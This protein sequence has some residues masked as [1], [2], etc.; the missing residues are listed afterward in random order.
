M[1]SEATVD[2]IINNA[3]SLA[4]SQTNAANTAA[5]SAI[6][7]SQG[8]AATGLP[9]VVYNIQA[10]EPP[11]A[12][13]ED[14]TLTYESQRDEIIQLLTDQMAEFFVLYYPLT[15]DAFDPAVN[16]LVN[17]ITVGG[18]GINPAVE[19]QIW[20]RDRDRVVVDG[21]RVEAQVMVD[22]ASRG[23]RFPPGVAAARLQQA[24]FEQ[25]MK[26]Q[27]QSRAVAIKQA[28]IE[29]ENLRFAVNLAIESRLRAL[30][31]AAEYLRA[32]MSG[33]DNAARVAS[34]NADVRARM[35]AA[36]A[37]LYRARLSRDEIA[38]RVPLANATNGLQA[39]GINVDGFYKG[40][41]ARV[42]A[43]AAAAD[44]YGSSAAAALSSLNS[45]ASV[46]SASFT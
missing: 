44:S 46:S 8:F 7:A 1:A 6:A 34:L 23:F 19:A 4:N 15:T 36:T 27:E 42:R 3:I 28:D 40:V 17:T 32:L 12:E 11:V 25:L 45:V 35:I 18:T 37:D 2:A 41:D 38:M 5:Q 43:A 22:A 31:A 26:T 33:A 13:V 20:Q 14:A 24:R 29:V 30:S 16:W 39:S 10:V 21:Q 9:P